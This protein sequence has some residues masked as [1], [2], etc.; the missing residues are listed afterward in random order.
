[1]HG[2]DAATS[3]QF[4]GA[5]RRTTYRSRGGIDK[6]TL[7]GKHF[8][9]EWRRLSAL[10]GGARSATER[11]AIDRAAELST[12]AWA[13]MRDPAASLDDRARLTN[14]ARRCERDLQSIARPKRTSGNELD[15]LA[16]ELTK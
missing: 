10:I 8:Q 2:I 16:A 13:A 14:I 6:R 1:M 12:A 9:R 4:P 11:S 7:A 5:I 3:Q 15:R